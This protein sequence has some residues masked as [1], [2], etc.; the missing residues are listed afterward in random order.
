LTVSRR[1]ERQ[2][3]RG[4]VIAVAGQLND[5]PSKS[6][7]DTDEAVSHGGPRFGVLHVARFDDHVEQSV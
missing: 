3:R 4:F 2:D 5:L 6:Q 7:K 1:R